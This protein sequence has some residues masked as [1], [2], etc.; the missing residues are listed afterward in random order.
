[1]KINIKFL[2]AFFTLISSQIFAQDFTR[3]KYNY[4]EMADDT[5]EC[6]EE[7][8]AKFDEPLEQLEYLQSKEA[9][10]TAKSLFESENKC[11]YTYTI[12]AWTL[13]RS[14]DWLQSMQLID[15][16]VLKFGN[17]PELILRRGY[18]NIEMAELGVSQKNIDG[19][20]VYKANKDTILYEEENFKKECYLAALS[21]FGYL[22]ETYQGRS[23]EVYISGYICHQ[24][25]E[26]ES[27]NNYL[28]TLLADEDYRE[29]ALGL[30]MENYMEQKNYSEAEK[31]LMDLEKASVK[32]AD[33]QKKYLE[34]YEKNGD[35]E[36]YKTHEKMYNFYH[37]SPPFTKW[38]YSEENLALLE[39][40]MDENSSKDKLKK[41][42]SSAN[43]KN[44]VDLCI[45]VLYMH[46][47]HG[48]GV[49]EEAEKI[50]AK[51]GTKVLSD[52]IQL[53]YHSNS[54]CTITKSASILAEIKDPQGWDVLVDYLPH[55]EKLP[56][57][58][59]PPEIP[60]QLIKFDKVKALDVLL[61]WTKGM[62]ENPKKKT[63]DPFAD[64]GN[65]F[66]GGVIYSPMKVYSKSEITKKANELGYS[67]ENLKILLE[68]I[69]G[70]DK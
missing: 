31:L 14:G 46:A 70:K 55:I 53:F 10:K 22:A 18:M 13:F 36:K 37:L 52:V 20:T 68:N 25:E 29:D 1:M 34:L 23:R 5:T 32:S 8:M 43:K 65:I 50:L 2:I 64:L 19:N 12:Y 67:E 39:F 21:D 3:T 28:Y 27:S 62:I 15:S 61:R 56:F 16:A 66:T 57:T 11:A 63:D 24:L 48:N 26:Y 49:E 6:S 44:G 59:T 40:F 54:T 45:S 69:Y 7:T 30:I 38:N 51:M 41:L 42:K 60:E 58:V 33:I 35:K 17:N 9:V 4:A 47:N